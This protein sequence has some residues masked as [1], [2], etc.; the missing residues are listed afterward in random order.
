MS[1]R[2]CEWPNCGRLAG[3]GWEVHGAYY[4]GP[5]YF[6]GLERAFLEAYARW[7]GADEPGDKFRNLFS[8]YVERLYPAGGMPDKLS[9]SRIEAR[10]A[11][12]KKTAAG[13]E[14]SIERHQTAHRWAGPVKTVDQDWRF[15]LETKDLAL[16][17]QV[18]AAPRKLKVLATTAQPG[19][20]AGNALGR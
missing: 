18:D 8:R 11:S 9:Q 20:S 2:L 10:A 15:D 1:N 12:W 19:V 3:P 6:P 17:R 14:F 16:L 7:D 5:H 4:C 13:L